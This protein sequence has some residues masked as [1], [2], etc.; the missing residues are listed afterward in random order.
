MWWVIV[1]ILLP[2]FLPVLGL[3]LVSTDNSAKLSGVSGNRRVLNLYKDGQLGYV[4]VTMA[5]AGFY[6]TFS[7]LL[8][9]K[10]NK[11][12]GWSL[13]VI[14]VAAVH[15]IFISAQGASIPTKALPKNK[16]GF[17]GRVIHYRTMLSSILSMI[18]AGW[19]F[20][21]LHFEVEDLEAQLKKAQPLSQVRAEAHAT[22]TTSSDAESKK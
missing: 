14:A 17:V 22:A 20:S 3:V 18:A 5:M 13:L 4:T 6:E 8:E 12:L 19:A 16:P 10:A 7:Y 1:N 15:G 2:A 21:N 11:F 9:H